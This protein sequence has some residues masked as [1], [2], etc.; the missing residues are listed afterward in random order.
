M[1]FDAFANGREVNEAISAAESQMGGV[2]PQNVMILSAAL[3]EL[4]PFG[5]V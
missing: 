5:F 3:E 1:E 4:V 2:K